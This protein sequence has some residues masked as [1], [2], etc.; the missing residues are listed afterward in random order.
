V[1]ALKFHNGRHKT[2][3]K[4]NKVS[5]S[6]LHILNGCEVALCLLRTIF[7]SLTRAHDRV[8]AQNVKDFPQ[9]KI[10]CEIKAPFLLGETRCF[11]QVFAK[12]RLKK[13]YLK[14]KNV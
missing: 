10:D 3:K 11:V 7:P 14:K 8:R 4:R 1:R 5:Y 12:N 2:Q 13:T 9:I 6:F